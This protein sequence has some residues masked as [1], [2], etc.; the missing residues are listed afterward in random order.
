MDRAIQLA[1]SLCFESLCDRDA[2]CFIYVNTFLLRIYDVKMTLMTV[3]ASYFI[4]IPIKHN[5]VGLCRTKYL[6]ERSRVFQEIAVG[7]SVT[8][9]ASMHLSE[10]ML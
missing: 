3:A 6:G 2:H 4:I 8:V 10:L 1:L 9:K 7:K 5:Y